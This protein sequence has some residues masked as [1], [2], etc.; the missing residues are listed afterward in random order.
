MGSIEHRGKNSWRVGTQVSTGDGYEW[1]RRPL[2]FPADMSDE[3]QREAAEV[4]LKRLE[5]EIAD[6]KLKPA[7][8]PVTVRELADK[9]ETRHLIPDCSPVTVKNY[10]HMLDKRILPKLGDLPITRVTPGVIADFMAEL[11]QE[12]RSTNRKPDDQL[13]HPRSP[14]DALK[15][16]AKPD[17]L[18][19]DRT[20]RHYYDC[21]KFMFEKAVQ[22]EMLRANPVAKVDRPKYRKRTMNFL[23][24]DQ[25][26]TLLRKLAAE[27]D[28]SFRAAVLLALLGGL[29]LGEVGELRWADVDWK[30]GAIDISRALKYTPK[31]GSFIGDPKSEAS[32]RVLE[33]PVGMMAVLHETKL[34]QEDIAANIG[35]RWHGDG[36]I[37]CNWDGSQQHHDTP[38][39]QWRRFAGKNGCKGIR[40]HDLRHTHATILLGNNLDAVSVASRLGHASAVTTLRDYAHVLRRRDRQSAQVMQSLIDRASVPEDKE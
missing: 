27:E 26:V 18:L 4:E 36:L 33:L 38:S 8:K 7:A 29:R 6:G 34:Y 13:K 12:K 10:R 14:A 15:M 32:A 39:K 9:W 35:D 40:F 25:A 31:E 28:M 11:R 2:K 3:K 21:M 23:N 30:N 17:K 1:I 16:T 5:V 37:V 19:G 22:W 20:A 24:D